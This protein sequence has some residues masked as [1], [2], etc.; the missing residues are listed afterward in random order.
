MMAASCIG[1]LLLVVCLEF[2]RRLRK[3][4]DSFIVRQFQRELNT[5]ASTASPD[6]NNSPL[7]EEPLAASGPKTHVFRANPLQQITRAIIHA[8]T[9]GVAYIIML[10]AMYYNGYFIIC[11][12]IG[13]YIGAFVFHWETLALG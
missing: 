12:F 5:R 13:A 11:I 1:V 3:E 8:V 6:G 9:F 10:L 4:Y 2:L 7:T